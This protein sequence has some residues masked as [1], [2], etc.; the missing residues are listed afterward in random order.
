MRSE[1]HNMTHALDI[2]EVS[3]GE[4]NEFFKDEKYEKVDEGFIK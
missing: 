1:F 4:N 2:S 3:S